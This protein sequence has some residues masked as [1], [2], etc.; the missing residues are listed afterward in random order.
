MSYS[1]GG[2]L[3]SNLVLLWLWRRPVATAPIQPL[4]WEP[5]YASGEALKRQKTKTKTKRIHSKEI[6][7][8]HNRI[9][10]VSGALERRLDPRP[11]Q[12]V[13]DPALLQLW[14]TLQLWLGSDP[15]PGNSTCCGVAKKKKKK[16]SQKEERVS[17][18]DKKFKS[19]S[20]LFKE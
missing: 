18:I 12:W 3:S 7:L 6:P 19:D 10:S 15:W 17:G 16:N 13:K 5:S 8:W 2:R 20:N 4:A 11:A 14:L 1:V 9:I